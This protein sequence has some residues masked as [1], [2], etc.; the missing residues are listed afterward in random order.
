M[1]V[2]VSIMDRA[3]AYLSVYWAAAAS[4]VLP[5]M[6]VGLVFLGPAI[7][8]VAAHMNRSRAPWFIKSTG[9]LAAVGAMI[10]GNWVFY[11][12]VGKAFVWYI[13]LPDAL[14]LIAMIVW[15]RTPMV[16]LRAGSAD[17]LD[18][19]IERHRPKGWNSLIARWIPATG[20]HRVLLTK[21]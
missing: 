7:C 9:L 18:S 19:K 5:V 8:K 14:F 2:V 17:A 20:D 13:W 3:Q 4:Y 1:N 16:H 6:M 10:A 12:C 15:L 21:R 11:Q